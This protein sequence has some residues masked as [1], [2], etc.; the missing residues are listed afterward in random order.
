MK[1]YTAIYILLISLF[2]SSST[3]LYA[4]NADK[5]AIKKLLQNQAHAWSKG[6][7]DEF[8][9]GYWQNDSLVFTGKKGLT[10]G[11]K[12]TMENYK[13]NYPDT[14]AM[15]QLHFDLLQL[16]KLSF[17]YYFVIGKFHLTRTAGDLEGYFT[18]LFKK[19]KN[20]W[21]IISDHTS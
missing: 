3:E 20:K 1:T 17:E 10:Y 2:A 5:I 7:I 8:M 19:I 9:K 12:T 4:Q 21:L 13:K 14:A 18:L 11:Y 6:N 16:K 15:G